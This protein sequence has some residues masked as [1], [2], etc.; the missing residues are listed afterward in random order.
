[1]KRSTGWM[2]PTLGQFCVFIKQAKQYCDAPN[3]KN[4]FVGQKKYMLRKSNENRYNVIIQDLL[5]QFKSE[6]GCHKIN[7]AVWSF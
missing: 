4:M 3:K 2:H 5:D 6:I 1:M 7:I